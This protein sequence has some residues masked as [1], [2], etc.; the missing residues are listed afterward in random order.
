MKVFRLYKRIFSLF[1]IIPGKA[2]PC[3]GRKNKTSTNLRMLVF[4]PAICYDGKRKI[5]DVNRLVI[6]KTAVIFLNRR[7]GNR[8]P[9][10]AVPCGNLGF[11]YFDVAI[12]AVFHRHLNVRSGRKKKQRTGRAL[13]HIGNQPPG[14][15]GGA[16][17][18]GGLF[19]RLPEEERERK[20]YRLLLTKGQRR[21]FDRLSNLKVRRGLPAGLP[22]LSALY[23]ES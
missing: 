15:P 21:G 17:G 10:G 23:G 9:K 4:L 22:E 19:C 13:R 5:Q 18:P 12:I 14:E 2:C 11:R 1:A 16:C 3:A 20:R 8:Q 6:R 7:A